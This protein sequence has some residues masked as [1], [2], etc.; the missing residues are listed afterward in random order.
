MVSK[1]QPKSISVRL[2]RG[3]EEPMDE[4]WKESTPAE[5]IEAVWTG[6]GTK[7]MSPDFRELLLAFNAANVEYLLVGAH[8][9][10]VYGHVRA[11]KDLDVWIRPEKNNADRVI[12]ALTSFGAPLIDLSR[13]D[14]TSSGTVFQIGVPPLRIDLLTTIDGVEFE[15]AWSDRVT[16]QFAGLPVF[17]ISR[18]RL[19]VNKKASGRLQDLADV[20]QLEKLQS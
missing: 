16:T 7:P 2:I 6:L 12:A 10:A 4:D 20:E 8:A 5:R 15:E 11:T 18:E 14:L 9:L 3:G 19:I 17:V 1:Q 13:D